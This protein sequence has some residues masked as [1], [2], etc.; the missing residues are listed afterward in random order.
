M[1]WKIV[2]QT[3]IRDFNPETSRGNKLKRKNQLKNALSKKIGKQHQKILK[4]VLGK[5]L[6]IDVCFYLYLSEESGSAK[7]DLDNLLKIVL[8]VFSVNM[9]NGQ[10]KMS[11]MGFVKDDSQIFRINCEKKIVN[12]PV[13]AGLDLKISYR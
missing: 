12:E 3:K 5:E 1:K 6:F 10:E 13:R 8:D 2:L 9:V 4:R 7:K 11:G